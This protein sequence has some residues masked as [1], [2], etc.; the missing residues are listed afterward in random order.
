MFYMALY[1][2]FILFIL[3]HLCTP[4]EMIIEGMLLSAISFLS[5]S[6]IN[7]SFPLKTVMLMFTKNERV[8]PLP[9]LH[10]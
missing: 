1:D 8:P 3:Q 5:A 4:V 9:L 10:L 6:S 7:A 2:V